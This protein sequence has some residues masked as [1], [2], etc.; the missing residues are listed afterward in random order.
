MSS[1]LQWGAMAR[2][3]GA[4]LVVLVFVAGCG[5]GD[6]DAAAWISHA[7]SASRTADEALARGDAD[8]ARAALQAIVSAEVPSSVADRDRRVLRADAF[9]RLAEIELSGGSPT[10][11]LGLADRGLAEGR[12]EDLFTA[13]LLV[14]RGRALEAVGRDADA[15]E[16]YHA[17]LLINEALLR[18][19]LG[20]RGEVNR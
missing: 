6:A 15:A 10:E 11:A 8:A 20:R 2:V 3:V 5:N 19:A 17:A 1:G 9:Y 16:E 7:S 4:W 18:E 13:N 14:A 12:A